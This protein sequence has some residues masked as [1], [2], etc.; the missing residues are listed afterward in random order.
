M[1]DLKVQIYHTQAPNVE[2]YFFTCN[3]NL[4]LSKNVPHGS[5]FD[6]HVQ[7]SAWINF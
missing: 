5:T 4:V 6:K 3:L 7:T 1:R 2:K